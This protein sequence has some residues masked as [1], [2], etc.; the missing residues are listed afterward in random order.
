MANQCQKLVLNLVQADFIEKLSKFTEAC[1]LAIK[2]NVN[3]LCVPKHHVERLYKI[4]SSEI[5]WVHTDRSAVFEPVDRKLSLLHSGFTGKNKTIS[6][7]NYS[8]WT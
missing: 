5:R 4:H 6:S 2:K 7:I 8:I 3:L 1:F